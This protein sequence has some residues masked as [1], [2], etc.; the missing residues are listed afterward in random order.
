MLDVKPYLV[1]VRPRGV[2]APAAVV[3]RAH[4]RVL[5]GCAWS[6]CSQGRSQRGAVGAAD[7]LGA[8]GLADGLGA[9]RQGVLAAGRRHAGDGHRHGYGCILGRPT[10]RRSARQTRRWPAPAAL[11]RVCRSRGS[12]AAIRQAVYRPP[13]AKGAR[14][15]VNL[16]RSTKHTVTASGAGG[17]PAGTVDGWPRS[18]PTSRHCGTRGTSGGSGPGRRSRRVGSQLTVVALAYQTFHLTHSTFMVGLLG[19]VGSG[20][21]AGRGAVGRDPGRCLGPQAGAD[22]HPDAPWRAAV[23]GLAVNASLD[24]PEVWV[25]FVC[26]A[27]SAGFQGMDWPARRAALPM[28]VDDDDIT[29]AVTLQTTT[30]ASGHGGRSRPR[31][32]AHR[33]PRAQHAS[34]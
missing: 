17:D 32:G 14:P 3:D 10:A 27:A 7:S 5:V 1:G 34:T 13:L 28:L 21:S 4:G 23:A 24:H 6:S 25:L 19:F 12:P 29:A 31:R 9:R 33:P 26:A 22:T 8:E 15:A 30:M 20:P 11:A 2:S 18:S 16:R